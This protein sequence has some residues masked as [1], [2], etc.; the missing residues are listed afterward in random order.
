MKKFEKGVRKN[1]REY[2]SQ[3]EQKVVEE[4]SKEYIDEKNIASIKW[5]NEGGSIHKYFES[6]SKNDREEVSGSKKNEAEDLSEALSED[7]KLLFAEKAKNMKKIGEDYRSVV[8]EMKLLD[9]IERE[10]LEN[11]WDI[12]KRGYASTEIGEALQT[13]KERKGSAEKRLEDNMQSNPEAWYV[14]HLLT[15]R[16]YKRSL[17]N[18]KLVRTPYVQERFDKVSEN[19][20]AAQPVF[21]SGH[22]GSGKSQLAF[23]VAEEVY[24]EINPESKEEHPF[25]RISGDEN[26]TRSDFFGRYVLKGSEKDPKLMKE[27]R[28]NA[29]EEF[30]VWAKKQDEETLQ[31]KGNQQWDLILA[32]VHNKLDTGNTTEFEYGPVYKAMEEGKVLVIDEANAI[33]HETLICLND[34]LASVRMTPGKN[35]VVLHHNGG[36]KVI[37]KPGFN[38]I[39]T[40]NL[41]TQTNSSYVGRQTLDPAF[42]S[43]FTRM[44]YDY[45]PQS[46]EGGLEEVA[47]GDELFHIMLA[48]VMDRRGNI[49]LPKGS[50]EKL[51]ELAKAARI[52]QESFSGKR[53]LEYDGI[54]KNLEK[55]VPSIRSLV[56]VFEAWERD[57]YRHTLDYHLKESF[58]DEIDDGT[59]DKD[60]I[61]QNLRNLGGFF[62]DGYDKPVARDDFEF[63][64]KEQVAEYAFGEAPEHTYPEAEIREEE[65][66]MM[67]IEESLKS[68]AI[69]L[70]EVGC[71][72]H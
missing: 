13:L 20:R 65:K 17:L 44:E 16:G 53:E 32:E 72:V 10:L 36:K 50:I 59:T 42:L 45:V 30:E 67:R 39:L 12:R 61:E 5:L 23:Q 38:I 55:N 35:T 34:I 22:L 48:K 60:F 58:V 26:V 25:Y 18:E 33:P 3:R 57:E 7:E 40:G 6:I 21:I 46:T 29:E 41:N 9:K 68:I 71:T 27:I 1:V 4:R 37:A 11:A 63:I 54:G 49:H 47:M 31:E 69:E 24:R 15:L 28:E 14:H 66:E 52:L 43:R 62:E 51:W 19:I 56:K 8:L 2:Q 70:Q 64:Y